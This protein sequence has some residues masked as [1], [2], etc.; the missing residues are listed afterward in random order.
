MRAAS[1]AAEQAW[2]DGFRFVKA[3]IMLT[4]L[5]PAGQAQRSLLA[6][7]DRE[8]RDRLMAGAQRREPPPRPRH[9]L[10]GLTRHAAHMGDEIRAEIPCY[11]TRLDELPIVGA[12][13][14]DRIP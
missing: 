6:A 8:R 10:S 9:A 14:D 1:R 7:I 5:V 12:A 2:R 4:E 3:G 13:G 11:T